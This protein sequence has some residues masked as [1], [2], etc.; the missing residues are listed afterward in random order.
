LRWRCHRAACVWLERCAWP[1]VVCSAPV[2]WGA[3]HCACT[4]SGACVLQAITQTVAI[5]TTPCSMCTPCCVS[6]CPKL[7]ITATNA[8]DANNALQVVM[9]LLRPSPS[10]A[11]RVV[12]RRAHWCVGRFAL[13][14]GAINLLLGAAL[15]HQFKGV[16]LVNWM[17]PV[18]LLLAVVGLLA[19]TLEAFKRQVCL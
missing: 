14:F 8:A 19:L 9:G 1:A 5:K 16:P 2:H 3:S 11:R 15:V 4:G 6:F 18:C 13:L 10:A 17:L 12:W 7:S